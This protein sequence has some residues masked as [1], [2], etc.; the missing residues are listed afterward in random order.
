M[1]GI[2]LI[3]ILIFLL[4]FSILIIFIIGSNINKTEDEKIVDIEE[5]Q[6][7]LINYKRH[8][9]KYSWEHIMAYSVIALNNLKHSANEITLNNIKLFIEPLNQLYT[10]REVVK[11]AKRLLSEEKENNIT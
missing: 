2:I 11:Y 6:Q 7:Y 1:L 3:T 10:K 8:K 9:E 5:E 4:L